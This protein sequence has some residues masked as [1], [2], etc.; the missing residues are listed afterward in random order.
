MA[1]RRPLDKY[2]LLQTKME[3]YKL[4]FGS[5]RFR[6]WLLTPLPR[7]QKGEIKDYLSD[8]DLCSCAG[9]STTVAKATEL[10]HWDT[11]GHYE[12][13]VSQIESGEKD[14]WQSLIDALRQKHDPNSRPTESEDI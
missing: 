11:N 13:V 9:N 10:I 1:L 12:Q 14:G 2:E 5:D 7:V 4:E 8:P 3:D 6:A